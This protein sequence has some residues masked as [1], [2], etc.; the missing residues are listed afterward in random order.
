MAD[1]DGGVTAESSP[2]T[3]ELSAVVAEV[4]KMADHIL[5]NLECV[6]SRPLAAPAAPPRARSEGRQRGT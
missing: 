6:W 3:A 1:D 4:E 5:A 2:P